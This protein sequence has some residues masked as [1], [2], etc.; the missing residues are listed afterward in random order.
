MKGNLSPFCEFVASLK[1]AAT[2]SKPASGP[3]NVDLMSPAVDQLWPE[4]RGVIETVNAWIQP[5]LKLFGVE[6]RNGLSPLVS[7]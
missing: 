6:D 5:F 2:S 7:A 4:V 1:G 3:V